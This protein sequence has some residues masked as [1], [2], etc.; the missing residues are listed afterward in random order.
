SRLDALHAAMLRVKLPFVDEWNER[1]REAARRY[2][3]LLRD[4]PG[5]VTPELVDEHVFHQ[6]T[7]RVLGGRRDEVRDRLAAAGVA[8][9]VYYPVPLDRLLV[10]AHLCGRCPA[11]D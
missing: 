6:Y 1:R 11:S 10:F 8:T 9:L 7:V 4:V 5:L 2:D 3:E